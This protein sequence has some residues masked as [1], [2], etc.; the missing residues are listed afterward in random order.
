MMNQ[1]QNMNN[2]Q[3]KNNA[4][5]VAYSHH[6]QSKLAEF[7]RTRPS[8]FSGSVSLVE[9]DDWLRVIERKL[10]ITQCNDHKKALYTTRQMEGIAA[11]WCE[12]FCAAHETL[13]NIT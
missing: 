13:Q 5:P 3:A 12:N 2:N 11:E 1:I 8:T 4:T 7:M 10:L 6:R 9:A